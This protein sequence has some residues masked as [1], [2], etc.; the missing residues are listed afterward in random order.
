MKILLTGAKGQLG[1][2]C[3]Q[4]LATSR[5]VYPFSSSELDITDQ[6]SVSDFITKIRPDIVVNCAAYT[7]VDDCEKDRER[8]R[9]VNTIGPGNLAR[10]C[11]EIDARLLHISTDYVFDGT[12]EPPKSY[13]ETDPVAP[14]SAYGSTKLDG[15]EQIR[16]TLENH[17]ILRT[18]WLYGIGGRNFLKTMLRLALADP[19]RTIRVVNDQVG[20]LTWTYR[21]A[22][23]IQV[24]AESDVTGTVHATAEGHCTWFEGAKCFLE[25]MAVPFSLAP[26]ATEEYPTPAHRPA[27]SILENSR[28]NK[29]RLN[30]MDPWQED[31]VKFAER[32]RDALLAEAGQVS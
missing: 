1:H 10:A 31:V 16:A 7:A 32:H 26:C 17:L 29:L 13:R 24:L 3:T 22:K 4:V 12:K 25:A 30:V 2:D 23:Q 21:L 8:C 14:I 5:T 20:S 9:M 11:K 28:L 27:N 18:A 19:D 6:E 15:E